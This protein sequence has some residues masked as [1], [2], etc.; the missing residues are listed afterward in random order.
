MS[1]LIGQ[2]NQ[3]NDCYYPYFSGST[4]ISWYIFLTEISNSP[5]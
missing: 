4:R 2:I 5:E 1:D 3:D